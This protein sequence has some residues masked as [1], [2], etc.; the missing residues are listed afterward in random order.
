MNGKPA[1]AKV[2]SLY[3]DSRYI[4]GRT[5]SGALSC[6]PW[7]LHRGTASPALARPTRGRCASGSVAA[8]RAGACALV[9]LAWP[10]GLLARV[11]PVGAVTA[12]GVDQPRVPSGCS[13]AMARRPRRQ[14]LPL[15]ASLELTSLGRRSQGPLLACIAGPNRWRSERLRDDAVSSGRDETGAS[16]CTHAGPAD[17]ACSALTAAAAQESRAISE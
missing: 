1:S 16:A 3:V 8:L 5:T 12:D 13:A 17:R 4:R 7:L 2:G 6:S 9:R 11:T 14:L 10:V 15:F